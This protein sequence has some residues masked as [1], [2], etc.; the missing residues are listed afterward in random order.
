MRELDPVEK[1]AFCIKQKSFKLIQKNDSVS[2]RKKLKSMIIDVPKAV[3]YVTS[4]KLLLGWD[5]KNHNQYSVMKS[6]NSQLGQLEIDSFRRRLYVS[7][8]EGLLLILDITCGGYPVLVHTMKLVKN[9]GI[10]QPWYVKGMQFDVERNLLVCRM[11][12]GV[13]Y[14]VQLFKAPLESHAQIIECMAHYNP[15]DKNV[16]TISQFCWVSRLGSYCE[17]T[18]LGFIKFRQADGKGLCNLQLPMLFTDKVKLLVHDRTKNLLFAT[19]RDGQAF[20]W[21]L[22]PE[23]CP[24][25]LEKK[26][27]EIRLEQGQ[28]LF[29]GI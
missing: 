15:T 11:S 7:T 24:P 20:A 13:L 1:G 21:K 5:L 16:E 22:P 25:W 14:F 27:R 18:K 29:K 2:T 4:E 17:G 28:S 6:S 19:S 26:L 9:P 23:W 12:S 10:V 8:R 3:L